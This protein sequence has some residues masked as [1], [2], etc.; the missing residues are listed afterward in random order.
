M[1]HLFLKS[2]VAQ[3]AWDTPGPLTD[4]V[5]GQ[6]AIPGNEAPSNGGRPP[7]RLSPTRSGG[8]GESPASRPQAL[9]SGARGFW[10]ALLKKSYSQ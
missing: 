3:G 6:C 7:I 2:P 8:R 1:E 5:L 9:L 4:C 10:A